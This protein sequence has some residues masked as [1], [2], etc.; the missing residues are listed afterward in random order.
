MEGY[1]NSLNSWTNKKYIYCYIKMSHF[2]EPFT[3]KNN[4][5]VELD[6]LI[7]QQFAKKMI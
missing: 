2:P 7:M 4:M 6:F 1:D 5:E 3:S